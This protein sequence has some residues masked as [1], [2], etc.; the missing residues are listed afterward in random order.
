MPTF[1]VSCPITVTPVFE[2][3]ATVKDL[4]RA[5]A[6]RKIMQLGASEFMK[7]VNEALDHATLN[8]AMP[9][10]IERID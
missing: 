1:K 6:L 3:K 5:G 2:L 7:Q 10:K 4:T 8:G 9:M